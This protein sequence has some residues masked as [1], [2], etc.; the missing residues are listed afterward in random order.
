MVGMLFIS[1]DDEPGRDE[2]ETEEEIEFREE[3]LTG[4][5]EMLKDAEKMIMARFSGIERPVQVPIV[6]YIRLNKMFLICLP[7]FV[8][9]I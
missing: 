4:D 5:M 3:D 2:D 8:S 7:K 9:Y 1:D 6:I